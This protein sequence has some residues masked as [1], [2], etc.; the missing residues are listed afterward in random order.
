MTPGP[1][2]RRAAVWCI[3]AMTAAVVTLTALSLDWPLIGDTAVMHFIAARIL[4]G[5]VPYRDLFDMNFPGVYVVHLAGIS[6]LGY[7][8]WVVRALDLAV[9]ALILAGVG[10]TLAR[11]GWV[12][13]ATAALIFWGYHITAG[14]PSAMQRDFLLCLP[15]AGMTASVAVYAQSGRLRWLVLAG[16]AVGWAAS[17]KPFAILLLAVLAGQA[18]AGPRDTR[19]WRLCAAAGGAAVS[20]AAALAWVTAV[21]GLPAFVDILRGYLP[22]Y[23]NYDRASVEE[24]LIRPAVVVLTPWAAV[25]AAVLWQTRRFDGPGIMLAAGVVFAIVIL[26]LQGKGFGY[27][28]YPLVLFAAALGAAGLPGALQDRRWAAVFVSLLLLVNAGLARR[29]ARYFGVEGIAADRARVAAVADLVRPVLARGRSVQ[30][31]DDIAGGVHALYTL[32]APQA[33]RFLYDFHF[34]HHVEHPYIRGLRQQLLD[35]LRVARPGAVVLFEHGQAPG[36]FGRLE[37]FPELETRLAEGYRL[38]QEGDQFR[39]YLARDLD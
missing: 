10:V 36:D 8:D 23:A 7:D 26:L 16:A 15:L 14:A 28:G 22:L 20:G 13:S 35:Q 11:F 30:M 6:L 24:I 34:Y 3:V 2:A 33:T 9:L 31:L 38:T 1:W 25:G 19:R 12:A 39:L 27:H 4:A 37:R 32:H 21:G 29:G 5:A 17:V 18:W